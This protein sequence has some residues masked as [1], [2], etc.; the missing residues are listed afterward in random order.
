MFA[1]PNHC[2]QVRMKT[3][4]ACAKLLSVRTEKFVGGGR[5]RGVT[6]NSTV[7]K[8][9]TVAKRP[10]CTLTNWGPSSAVG[11]LKLGLTFLQYMIV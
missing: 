3:P 1:P 7:P 4:P 9:G 8:G 10:P 5:T 2:S 6:M 11:R